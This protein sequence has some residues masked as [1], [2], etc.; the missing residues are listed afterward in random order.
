MKDKREDLVEKL[1]SHGYIKTEK[2]KKAMLSVPKKS[3]CLPKP[4]HMPT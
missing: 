1:T 4:D 3:S 2:V